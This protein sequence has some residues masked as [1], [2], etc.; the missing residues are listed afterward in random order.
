MTL[1]VNAGGTALLVLSEIYYPGWRA[2]VNGQA[3]EIQKVNG[4]MR[5]IVVPAGA[6]HV[7][8]E[9]TP[10]TAYARLGA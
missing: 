10:L 7:T 8:L 2:A 1:D 5:G 3:A 4:A 9:F 6:S